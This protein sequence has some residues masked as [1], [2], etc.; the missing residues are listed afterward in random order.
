M[1]SGVLPQAIGGAD[2]APIE[3]QIKT[4]LANTKQALLKASNPLPTHNNWDW[5]PFLKALIRGRMQPQGVAIPIFFPSAEELRTSPSRPEPHPDVNLVEVF[6]PEELNKNPGIEGGWKY[7]WY[8]PEWSHPNYDPRLE[9]NYPPAFRYR[10]TKDPIAALRPA[11]LPADLLKQ[12]TDWARRFGIHPD[13]SGGRSRLSPTLAPSRNPLEDVAAQM[14]LLSDQEAARVTHESREKAQAAG[15]TVSGTYVDP[16]ILDSALEKIGI[17]RKALRDEITAG[18]ERGENVEEIFSRKSK[19]SALFGQMHGQF[20]KNVLED[21]DWQRFIFSDATSDELV[22]YDFYSMRDG[23]YCDLDDEIHPYFQK[24][25]WLKTGRRGNDKHLPRLLYNIDGIRGEY[26]V[27]N[28]PAVWEALQPALKLATKILDTE[29][30]ALRSMMDL[31]TRKIVN[32]NEDQRERPLPKGE[33]ENLHFWTWQEEIKLEESEPELQALHDLGLDWVVE[34]EDFLADLLRVDICSAYFSPS[35]FP[36]C[37]DGVGV[38]PSGTYGVANTMPNP[39]PITADNPFK[40]LINCSFAA[41]LI[42]PLLTNQSSD[43]EKLTASYVIATTLVHELCHAINFAHRGIIAYEDEMLHAEGT[44]REMRR[45]LNQ[46]GD[47]L[48]GANRASVEPFWQ[49]NADTELGFDFENLLW[50]WIPLNVLSNFHTVHSRMIATVPILLEG[51]DSPRARTM[52]YELGQVESSRPRK[53]FNPVDDIRKHIPFEHIYKFFT[54]EFWDNEFPRFGHEAC[55]YHSSDYQTKIGVYEGSVTYGHLVECF[56]KE[57]YTFLNFVYLTLMQNDHR[58]LAEWV[59]QMMYRKVLP[60]GFG[61]RYQEILKTT[62]NNPDENDIARRMASLEEAWAKSLQVRRYRG[63]TPAMRN[64]EYLV[65]N[66]N[67]H[68]R[69][70]GDRKMTLQ[71][72]ID[73]NNADWELFFGDSGILLTYLGRL[74]EEIRNELW[75]CEWVVFT[76][77]SMDVS[78]RGDPTSVVIHGREKKIHLL[79]LY[80]IM[81]NRNRWLVKVVDMIND[82]ENTPELAPVQH[83]WGEWGYRFSEYSNSYCDLCDMLG[84]QATLDPE[85]TTWKN[86]MK[87]IPSAYHKNRL[88]RITVLF[89]REYLRVDPDIRDVIDECDRIFRNCKNG[90]GVNIPLPTVPSTEEELKKLVSNLEKLQPA[91][92]HKTE[93]APDANYWKTAQPLVYDETV[94]SGS[95]ASQNTAP[96]AQGATHAHT[97]T[98]AGLSQPQ[99]KPPNPTGVLAAKPPRRFLD[100]DAV[101]AGTSTDEAGSSWMQGVAADL[102]KLRWRRYEKKDRVWYSKA[103]GPGESM[104]Q[105]KTFGTGAGP[106]LGSQRKRRGRLFGVQKPGQTQRY[107]HPRIFKHPYARLETTTMDIRDDW[108]EFMQKRQEDIDQGQDSDPDPDAMDVDGDPE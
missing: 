79:E 4:A 1:T 25:N 97:T 8:I 52:A 81:L 61:R 15:Q 70:N 33:R 68:P 35:H 10:G 24:E 32:H 62:K 57:G 101:M 12:P 64:Q 42:W 38:Q 106:A 60:S 89:H 20:V 67:W 36:E 104:Q 17:S 2:T 53:G 92:P 3:Q 69:H 11:L 28:N 13:E 90:Y 78:T 94:Q 72:K 44:D 102:S 14:D 40:M 22:H 48:L 27:H 91:E 75:R 59:H 26:D 30:F 5:D 83:V 107:I 80:E 54:K 55:K 96:D 95:T 23:P 39:D 86:E 76:F 6:A 41:E 84:D 34:T 43:S 29:P 103:T 31:R 16:D 99:E 56:G 66:R 100:L 108:A 65:Y 77:F 18:L 7:V 45:L 63:L 85:D 19:D 49:G 37:P 73:E 87:S 50:G 93:L 74:A 88:D 9:I 21:Q 46:L 58:I 71:E 82:I 98:P 47:K 105:L 51:T